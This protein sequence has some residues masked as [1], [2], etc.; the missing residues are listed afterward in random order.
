MSGYWIYEE[1]PT[2]I[3]GHGPSA[4]DILSPMIET[5]RAQVKL[6][7]FLLKAK[8]WILHCTKLCDDI[9]FAIVL[10]WFKYILVFTHV[11]VIP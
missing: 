1:V 6:F 2:T 4:D 11:D 9:N 8:L 3:Q 7:K 10:A 5:C